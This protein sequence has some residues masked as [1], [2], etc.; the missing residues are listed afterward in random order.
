MILLESC[1]IVS[2]FPAG[3]VLFGPHAAQLGHKKRIPYRARLHRHGR[4]IAAVHP[5]DL[6]RDQAVAHVVHARAAIGLGQRAAQQAERAHLGNDLAIEALVAIGLDNARHEPGLGIVPRAVA[7]HALV[8]GE[9]SLERHGM[10]PRAPGQAAAR[11]LC[12]ERAQAGSTR[13]RAR[14]PA[15]RGAL[16]SSCPRTLQRAHQNALRAARCPR[17]RPRKNKS[18]PRHRSQA[19]R[20]A[21]APCSAPD[22]R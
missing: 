22:S 13:P 1:S 8:L 7:D 17:P 16:R 2:P 9:L 15:C 4:A 6:A 19:P 10:R 21:I 14:P 5:L 18:A 20:P 11:T 12:P 3:L